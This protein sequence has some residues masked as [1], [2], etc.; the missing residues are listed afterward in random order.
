[1]GV[2]PGRTSQMSS[3]ID[4]ACEIVNVT[5]FDMIAAE[6]QNSGPNFEDAHR[7]LQ[8]FSE[9]RDLWKFAIPIFVQTDSYVSKYLILAIFKDA[10]SHLWIS[11]PDSSKEIFKNFFFRTSTTNE[12]TPE[13]NVL[14]SMTDSILVEILKKEWKQNW[15]AF[16]RDV[17]TISHGF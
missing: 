6:I 14:M 2:E 10:L 8:Q 1:M 13:T 4:P 15:P 5:E 9:R 17:S 11:I 3:L 12:V 16:S 7:I